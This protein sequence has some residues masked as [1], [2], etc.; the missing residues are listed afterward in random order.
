[1]RKA[2]C[3]LAGFLLFSMT[4]SAQAAMPTPRQE[5]TPQEEVSQA[6]PRAMTVDDEVIERVVSDLW[7][8]SF[9]DDDGFLG[10]VLVNAISYLDAVQLA[11]MLGLN[12]GGEILGVN[13]QEPVAEAGLTPDEIGFIVVGVWLVARS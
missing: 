5:G 8:L 2:L 11:T 6:G 9:A 4:A 1:M 10:A 13:L 3:T 12:P 7:W